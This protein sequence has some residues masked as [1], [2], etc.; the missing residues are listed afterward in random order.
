MHRGAR[1]L[2]PVSRRKAL[3]GRFDVSAQPFVHEGGNRGGTRLHHRDLGAALPVSLFGEGLGV[4]LQAIQD[5]HVLIAKLQVHLRVSRHDALETGKEAHPPDGPDAALS[6]LLGKG[7]VH[8]VGELDQSMAGVAPKRHRRGARVILLSR[9]GHREI[10]RA[11]D[12]GDHTDAL[13]L[14]LEP[15]G[16]SKTEPNLSAD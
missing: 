12:A 3:R 2:H 16:H 5:C 9:R 15:G 1:H 14:V 4:R 13:P 10:A 7:L 6:R 11:D 8:A